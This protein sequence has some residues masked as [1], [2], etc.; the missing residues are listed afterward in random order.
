MFSVHVKR[1]C[2]LLWSDGF[3]CCS[4]AQSCPALCDLMDCS[5]PGFPVHHH[6]PEL[7]QTHVHW[8][9]D[10]IQSSHPLSSLSSAFNLSQLQ[11]LFQWVSSLYQVAKILELQLQHQSFQ[12]NIQGWFLLRL[13]GLLSL[14][15]KG[16]S[17]IFSS[18]RVQKHQFF[19][20]QPS[21]WSNSH[22]HTSLLGKK[23]SFD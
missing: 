2:I 8:V 3:C 6:L 18:T 20:T 12:V 16:F 1:M 22:I 14:L 15:S 7:A 10:A 11:G 17:R 23:N 4:V 5:T 21:L 13:T 19:S 9:G